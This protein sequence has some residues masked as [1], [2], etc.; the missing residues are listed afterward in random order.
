MESWLQKRYKIP[1]I[2][3]KQAYFLLATLPRE[4]KV[5]QASE[6]PPSLAAQAAHP[7]S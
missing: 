1:N 6:S 7:L 5:A 3:G 2:D 4:N